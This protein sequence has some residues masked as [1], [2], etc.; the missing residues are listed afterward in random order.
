MDVKARIAKAVRMCE[1]AETL[2]RA[3]EFA[4]QELLLV[5]REIPSN[6]MNEYVQQTEELQEAI[7]AL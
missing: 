1:Q 2:K 6:Y 7:E 5:V 3:A 4:E